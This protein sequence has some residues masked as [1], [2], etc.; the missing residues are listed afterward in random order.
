MRKNGGELCTDLPPR[1][2]LTV[3]VLTV[4]S[5]KELMQLLGF[6]SYPTKPKHELA[7]ILLKKLAH[8][9]AASPTS[10]T[11]D[12]SSPKRKHSEFSIADDGQR[13]LSPDPTPPGLFI[14]GGE[15]SMESTVGDGGENV[16]GVVDASTAVANR[17]GHLI[18]SP[19]VAATPQ[20]KRSR[21]LGADVARQVT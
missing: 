19:A 17:R 8:A 12:P 21:V 7:E 10:S 20:Q 11:G 6:D 5:G 3:E 18:R 16:P 13:Q 14:A 2:E 9:K 4:F 1:E 15:K